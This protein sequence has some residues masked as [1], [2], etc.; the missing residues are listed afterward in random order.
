VWANT[1]LTVPRDAQGNLVRKLSRLKA[2]TIL[3]LKEKKKK[4]KADL[5]RIEQELED[6]LRLKALDACCVDLDHKVHC[7]E[8]ACNKYLREDEERWRLKSRMLWL[9]GEDTNIRF[10]HRV[11][12][13][14]RSK[15]YMWDIEEE[16]GKIH[17]TT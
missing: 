4:E 2:I 13:S 14:R 6:L 8:E 17:Q 9:A 12:N 1:T 5:C 11:A 15:K 7:L 10:F 3:W 16:D